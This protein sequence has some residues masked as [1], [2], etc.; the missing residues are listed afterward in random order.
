M[1]NNLLDDLF[2]IISS[3]DKSENPIES[4]ELS[5]HAKELFDKYLPNSSEDIG[6]R[7]DA[8]LDFIGLFWDYAQKGFAAGFNA[9]KELLK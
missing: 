1:Y 6:T 8:E 9:A 4:N 5:R 7:N 2:E 3:K